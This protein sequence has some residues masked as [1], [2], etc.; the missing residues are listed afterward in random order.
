[1]VAGG[2]FGLQTGLKELKARHGFKTGP[3]L[4]TLGLAQMDQVLGEGYS[5]DGFRSDHWPRVVSNL[6]ALCL[7]VAPRL[8][9]PKIIL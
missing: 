6:A 5:D 9:H 7:K 1:M 4:R 8:S 2:Q 3:T